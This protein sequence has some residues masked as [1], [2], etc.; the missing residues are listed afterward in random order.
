MATKVWRITRHGHH[1][2]HAGRNITIASGADVL[3]QCF[4]WL[5]ATNINLAMEFAVPDVLRHDYPRK[6]HATSANAT[7]T[8]AT[9][10]Q[11]SVLRATCLRVGLNPMSLVSPFK[12]PFMCVLHE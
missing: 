4:V 12:R 9:T 6:A 10:N 8:A 11:I 2:T 7:V 3:L 1:M 5:H